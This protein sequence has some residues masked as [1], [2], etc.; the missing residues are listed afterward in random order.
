MISSFRGE[1]AFLSNFYQCEVEFAGLKYHSSEAA[2]QACK[3]LD[4][5]ERFKLTRLW[6]ARRAKNL[7]RK[8]TLRSDWNDVKIGFMREVLRSKFYQ[9]KDLAEEL[10]DTKQEELVEGNNWKDTFWGVCKEQGENHL[11]K[12]LMELRSEIRVGGI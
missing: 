5:S 6:E 2:Y 3:T 8:L 12:L 9:N 4:E 10:L 11:G 1:Y 7:G